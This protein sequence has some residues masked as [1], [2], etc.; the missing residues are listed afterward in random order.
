MPKVNR[1]P[2]ACLKLSDIL[3]LIFKVG[4]LLFYVLGISKVM[5]WYGLVTLHTHVDFIVLPHW[6]T[7]VP[8]P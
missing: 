2:I 7:R 5:V 1:E 3:D 6:K 8:V 4:L